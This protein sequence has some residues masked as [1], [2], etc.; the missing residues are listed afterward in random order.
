MSAPND[1]LDRLPCGTDVGHLLEQVDGG[2]AAER[3]EHQVDCLL[4]QAA[5]AELSE[6]WQPLRALTAETVVAPPGLVAAVMGR[7]PAM[8]THAWYALLP[9]PS[10]GMGSRGGFSRSGA[11][12]V[13]ARVVGVI[14]RQAAS[15][16]PGVLAALGEKTSRADARAAERSTRSHSYPGSAVGVAGGHVVV[17][18]AVAVVYGAQIPAVADRVRRAVVRAVR[19]STGLH[20]VRVDITVDDVLTP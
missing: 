3:D 8:T 7:I 1:D 17:E 10:F 9:E 4:F 20:D 18:L 14:A 11:T 19:A 12:W 5:L 13:A 15:Q 6:V 16:V 2:R